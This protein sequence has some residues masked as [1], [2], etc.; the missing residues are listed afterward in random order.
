MRSKWFTAAWVF[1]LMWGL[2]LAALLTVSVSN[3]IA[4][5]D[6]ERHDQREWRFAQLEVEYLK[7]ME[8]LHRV[9]PDTG[10][11]LDEL[12]TRFDVF[13]SRV[14][15]A[16]ATADGTTGPG[17]KILQM[18]RALDG[19]IP[20]IDGGNAQLMARLDALTVALENQRHLSRDIALDSIALDA[21]ASERERAEIIY[22]IR[23]LVA[24]ILVIAAFLVF[25]II[26]LFARSKLLRV[27]TKE[28]QF[29]EARLASM[30]RASLD[31]VFVVDEFGII[32]ELNE[33]AETVFKYSRDELLGAS[34]INMLIPERHRPR[35]EKLLS[36]FRASGETVVADRGLVEWKLIDR[37][38]R[39][40]YAEV[41]S[42]HMRL[43]NRSMFVSYMRD[44]TMAKEKEAEILQVRDEALTAYKEKSRFFAMMS[45]EMRTPLNGVISALQ[46]LG[47]GELD[48]TQRRYLTAAETSGDILLGHINDVLA[49]ERYE[50]DEEAELRGVDVEALTA[51]M[52]GA[53]EPF[54]AL[55]G[56]RL[57]VN[58]KGLDGRTILTDY[59]AL[60]QIMVNLL[61]NAIKF[62][63]GGTVTLAARFS[64]KKM[65]FEVKDTGTG[66]SKADIARIF[67]DFVSLDSSYERRT[68]GTG[69]GLGIV[70]RLVQRLG[71]TITCRSEL[72]EGTTFHVELPAE[73]AAGA[74][75]VMVEDHINLPELPAQRCLVVDDNTV[76][77][78]LM[79]A[80][81]E[82]MGH[83]VTV[84]QSGFEAVEI[85]HHSKFDLIL[86]D[87]SM[88]GMSGIEATHVIKDSAGPNADTP[89][90]AV[91]AHALPEQREEFRA[92]GLAG[93]IEKPVRREMLARVLF[94]H[95]FKAAAPPEGAKPNNAK[96]VD[97]MQ[98]EE[99]RDVLGVSKFEQQ[100]QKF[101]TQAD[102]DIAALP[103]LHDTR[104]IREKC[105]SLAGLCGMMGAA[106]MHQIGAAVQ[107]ACDAGQVD[108]ISDRVAQL[109]KAWPRTRHVFE[110]LLVSPPMAGALH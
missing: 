59:R 88:P 29:N 36:D 46:L 45:H 70:K 44:I 89:F 27:A 67:D 101:L 31:A 96:L 86:M 71:G 54:A 6:P 22:L 102:Q 51:S 103:G 66:I 109:A 97:L 104:D 23:I 41:V 48:A 58:H 18:Q 99:L 55:S 57:V 52:F 87:I 37:D 90:A 85:A 15:L 61:S 17:E 13:Y 34:M 65:V 21:V 78:D 81:L 16:G 30:L 53:M 82:R 94:D 40:F 64:G 84:A 5:L 12:R 11:G 28:S 14:K 80:M 92:A 69:L 33:T 7:V 8:A 110:Q 74:P 26:S 35:L 19:F 93:F 83:T 100:L 25:A 39:E 72:G 49:I 32:H 60:Q 47:D 9:N 43:G 1:T 98:I 20:A 73:V 50:S 3:R 10:E 107:D 68:G 79:R 76:N 24:V 62:S 108:Q 91:T 95:C 56:V 4:A 77:R 2:G 75:A 63:P 38:G 106:Q 42:T 105:H